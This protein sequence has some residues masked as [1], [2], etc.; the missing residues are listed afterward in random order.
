MKLAP[1]RWITPILLLAALLLGGTVAVSSARARISSAPAEPRVASSSPARDVGSPDPNLEPAAPQI[2]KGWGEVIDPDG[3][4]AITLADGRLVIKVPGKPHGLEAEGGTLNAPRVLRDIEGD[5]IAD[6]EVGGTLKPEGP[7]P[8]PNI[9]PF[10]GAG[11]LLWNDEGNYIRL[12]RAA[13]V[14]NGQLVPYVLFQERKDRRRVPP[15][16][17]MPAPG[18]TTILRLERKGDLITAAVSADGSQWRAFPARTV[19]F[20]AK[21]KLGVAAITSSREP[22]TVTLTNF[23]VLRPE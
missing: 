1:H 16:G 2:L 10:V 19:N 5:F 11:L 14:R 8:N 9:F 4:C 17:G 13:I 15:D 12:E 20:P 6:L 22:F 3:D 23:R 7:P 21:L 18:G